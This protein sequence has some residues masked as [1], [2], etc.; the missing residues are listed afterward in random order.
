M[1]HQVV[2]VPQAGNQQ[3]GAVAKRLTGCDAKRLSSINGSVAAIYGTST[4][5]IPGHEK[6]GRRERGKLKIFRD[7]EFQHVRLKFGVGNAAARCS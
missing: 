3:L 5:Q 2:Q 6:G 1:R 7:T 4:C